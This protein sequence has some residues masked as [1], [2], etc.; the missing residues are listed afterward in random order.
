MTS[1]PQEAVELQPP[2]AD[3]APEADVADIF[4]SPAAE[5]AADASNVVPIKRKRR[6]AP[7]KEEAAAPAAASAPKKAAKR[8]KG[9][10]VK[11]TTKKAAAKAP[12]KKAAAKKTKPAAK[13]AKRSAARSP[14]KAATTATKPGPRG[15]KGRK[16]QAPKPRPISELAKA[17]EKALTRRKGI[18]GDEMMELG[19]ASPTSG[20]NSALAIA[21]R[22]KRKLENIGERG[23][24]CYRFK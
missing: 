13:P 18:T 15:G 19:Y 9:K 8:E 7:K 12:A 16:H 17:L 11:T 2:G 14:V 10:S 23:A 3:N 1:E 22:L 20:R 24:S 4:G 21:K 5:P 6:S